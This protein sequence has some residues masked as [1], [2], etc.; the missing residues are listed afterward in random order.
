MGIVLSLALDSDIHLWTKVHTKCCAISYFCVF[1]H[2]TWI[3]T[4]VNLRLCLPK[5]FQIL[6]PKANEP[7]LEVDDSV[8]CLTLCWHSGVQ[9]F[10]I[11]LFVFEVDNTLL[12]EC[13]V[14]TVECSFHA[15]SKTPLTTRFWK[16][17]QGLGRLTSRFPLL[18]LNKIAGKPTEQFNLHTL[19]I[20][21]LIF[22]GL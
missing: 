19:T 12:I 10:W 3:N 6:N 9:A 11:F 20:Y 22:L 2:T 16:G 1:V 8:Q 17:D 4:S 18:W 13:I 7:V 5:L 14:R 15:F 21:E